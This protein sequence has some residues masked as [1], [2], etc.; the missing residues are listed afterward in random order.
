MNLAL[1]FKSWIR[2]AKNFNEDVYALALA[3]QDPRVPW[4]AKAF[5]I[6]IVGYVLSPI[7][8]IPDFIPI[9]GSFDE[10][11]IVPLGI[12]IL[13]QMIP[14]NVWEECREK[15]KA[16]RGQM[17]GKHWL[18]SSIIILAWLVLIY[19]IMRITYLWFFMI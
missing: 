9:I 1:I 17:K 2:K 5:A 3:V 15:A 6:I 14:K 7:D 4:Y 11:I 13:V 10:L 12:I 16:H 19:L 8:P 18:A